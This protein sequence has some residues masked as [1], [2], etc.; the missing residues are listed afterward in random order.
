MEIF[1]DPLE[2]DLLNF[3]TREAFLFAKWSEW[4]SLIW[5]NKIEGEILLV[6]ALSSFTGLQG[7]T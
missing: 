6:F 2:P 1:S 7:T 4:K 5:K 3:N